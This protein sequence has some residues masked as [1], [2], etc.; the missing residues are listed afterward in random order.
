MSVGVSYFLVCGDMFVQAFICACAQRNAFDVNSVGSTPIG[1]QD[2][3]YTFS[4]TN[5]ERAESE[6]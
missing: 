4:L 1:T 5:Q 2:Q 3:L 6:L